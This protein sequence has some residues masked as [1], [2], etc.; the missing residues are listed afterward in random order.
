MVFERFSSGASGAVRAAI[1]RRTAGS[2]G[3]AT[4]SGTNL[5]SVV[6]KNIGGGM[7][8]G[9]DFGVA[10]KEAAFGRMLP[11]LQ[12]GGG[13]GIMQEQGERAGM[14][15]VGN[16]RYFDSEDFT[17]FAGRPG[18]GD[19]LNT[20]AQSGD[21]TGGLLDA[22]N[23]GDAGAQRIVD[24]FSKM[25][26][27]AQDGDKF[28]QGRLGNFQ[29]AMRKFRVAQAFPAMQ[30]N[31]ANIRGMA[32]RSLG[33]GSVEGLSSEAQAGF[34]SL[35]ERFSS[36]TVGN[37]GDIMDQA[38][39]FA[40]DLSADDTKALRGSGGIGRMVAGLSM[41]DDAKL[42]G[43]GPEFYQQL[44]KIA[45]LSGFDLRKTVQKK[46]DPYVKDG[47]QDREVGPI[48]KILEDAIKNVG[49]GGA[50]EEK[51]KLISQLT[52]YTR[53]NKQFVDAVG[54][55]I[56]DKIKNRANM[57]MPGG[58]TKRAGRGLFTPDGGW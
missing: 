25:H 14:L 56:G 7:G 11:L 4:V 49:P 5:L 38:S 13:A 18:M 3:N 16:G 33:R 51:Q 44:N 50:A 21:I 20:M 28:Y 37:R 42:T 41:L 47:V 10:S 23:A 29:N 12:S 22:L 27:G 9:P 24:A 34:T 55:V 46:L 6:Q 39:R 31:M 32:A 19:A 1:K 35:L 45:G 52:E 53:A 30:R 26:S 2:R 58:E 15:L 57:S 36:G 48:K 43:T 17:D 8:V 54:D 40:E